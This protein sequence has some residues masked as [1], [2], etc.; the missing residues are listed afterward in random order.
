MPICY[1]RHHSGKKNTLDPD[2]LLYSKHISMVAGFPYSE[3]TCLWKKKKQN[4]PPHTLSANTQDSSYIQFFSFCS[5]INGLPC[6]G[7][8]EMY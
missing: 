7:F 6:H 2:F 8:D 5:T 3:V 1:A 4:Q